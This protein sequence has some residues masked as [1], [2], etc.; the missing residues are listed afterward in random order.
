MESCAPGL[1]SWNFLFFLYI[2]II[3]FCLLYHTSQFASPRPQVRGLL[4]PKIRV[5]SH[6]R[7]ILDVTGTLKAHSDK[8]LAKLILGTYM[9]PSMYSKFVHFSNLLVVI[10]QVHISYITCLYIL[11]RYYTCSFFGNMVIFSHSVWLSGI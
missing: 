5:T 7:C 3:P 10:C 2:K 1:T 4:N 9:K 11:S 6:S 8:L